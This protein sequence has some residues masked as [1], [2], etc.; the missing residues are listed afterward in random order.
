MLKL[1]ILYCYLFSLSMKTYKTGHKETSNKFG[2][3]RPAKHTILNITTRLSQFNAILQ[4]L[5]IILIHS[6]IVK[7]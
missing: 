3:P 6:F 4:Y 5:S 1:P 7:Q 2:T